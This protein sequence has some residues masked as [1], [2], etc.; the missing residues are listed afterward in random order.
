MLLL[1]EF[2]V[3]DSAAGAGSGSCSRNEFREVQ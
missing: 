1:N 3:S 2:G